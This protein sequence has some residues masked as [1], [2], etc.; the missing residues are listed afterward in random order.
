VSKQMMQG[1]EFFL[2]HETTSMET[3]SV[4]VET[5]DAA[6]MMGV[7]TAQTAGGRE[8]EAE[9][10]EHTTDV[11]MMV[12]A[13]E[14]AAAVP[15]VVVG[16]E[17]EVR[18]RCFKCSKKLGLAAARGC[19]AG[20]IA[21]RARQWGSR[22]PGICVRLILKDTGASCCE[23]PTRWFVERRWTLCNP[24]LALGAWCFLFCGVYVLCC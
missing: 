17:Q 18:E 12:V 13:E 10:L 16:Q 6:P 11:E 3:H 5:S 21:G 22:I 1:G 23:M 20:R 14:A 24:S 2:Q 19:S 7:M 15:H 8:E 4:A 9:S